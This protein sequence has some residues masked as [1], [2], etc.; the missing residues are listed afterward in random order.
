MENAKEFVINTQ[1]TLVIRQIFFYFY[2]SK[3]PIHK[4]AKIALMGVQLVIK[5]IHVWHVQMVL[6]ELKGKNEYNAKL[7]VL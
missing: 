3:I 1:N 6:N 7:Y 4:N 5:K 2:S